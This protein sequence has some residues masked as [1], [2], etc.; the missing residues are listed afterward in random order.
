MYLP[1]AKPYIT[2]YSTLCASAMPFFIVFPRI[3]VGSLT[4]IAVAPTHDRYYP[5]ASFH[6]EVDPEEQV[7][8]LW[9]C[10]FVKRVPHHI[11][12]PYAHESLSTLS[13]S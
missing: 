3:H 6:R 8:V 11:I 10:D 2:G 12:R 5:S 4:Q 13:F 9:F 7:A 1:F